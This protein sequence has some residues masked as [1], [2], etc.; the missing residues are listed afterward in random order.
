M[1]TSTEDKKLRLLL[2]KFKKPRQKTIMMRVD[3]D[4]ENADEAVPGPSSEEEVSEM[5]DY[6]CFLLTYHY[7]VYLEVIFA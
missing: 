7:L 5:A 2:E 3:Y 4:K 1:P 6:L